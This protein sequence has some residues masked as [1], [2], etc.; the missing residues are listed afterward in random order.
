VTFNPFAVKTW[1]AWGALATLAFAPAALASHC[2]VSSGSVIFGHYD[3]L[4]PVPTDATATLQVNCDQPLP[5]A[6]K[7]SG[8]VNSG[9]SP[10]RRQMR[11]GD[12]RDPLYYNLFLDPGLSSIW[13]DGSG[14]TAIYM[15]SGQAQ[16]S[17]VVYGR[18]PAL[19]GV[20]P[21]VYTDTVTITV[22]W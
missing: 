10:L 14:A 21:G 5:Y 22:E 11:S 16:N 18:V 9:G 3:T 17:I 15:G 1:H 13:G 2:A 8:G 19:Q 7:L 6:I 4:S 20:G 12:G